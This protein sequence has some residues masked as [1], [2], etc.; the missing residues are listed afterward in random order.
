MENLFSVI[1]LTAASV[2]LFSI[3]Y[4]FRGIYRTYQKRQIREKIKNKI[5]EDEKTYVKNYLSYNILTDYIDKEIKK[6]LNK[7][8]LSNL[9]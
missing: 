2:I 9:K 3:Y 8:I 5:Y 6:L 7:K 4:G 1:F